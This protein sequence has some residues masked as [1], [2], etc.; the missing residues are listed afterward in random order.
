MPK[1]AILAT[2]GVSILANIERKLGSLQ[3]PPEVRQL[4][5]GSSRL[6]PDDPRQAEFLRHAEDLESPLAKIVLDEVARDPRGMSAE[7]NTIISF[8][9]DWPYTPYIDEL[10]IYLYPTDTGTSIF[11]A[12]MIKRY[13]TQHRDRFIEEARLRRECKI[14]CEVNVLRRFGVDEQFFTEGLD[15]LLNKYAERIVKLKEEKF[16]VILAPVGGFKPECTYATIIGLLCGVDKV[17]YIH[18]VFRY[19]VDLPIIPVDISSQIIKLVEQI[20]TEPCP[21]HII[22]P[23]VENL[24]FTVEEL[25]D[26]KILEEIGGE[27]RIAPWIIKILNLKGFKPPSQH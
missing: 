12:N 11:C 3:V 10:R 16:K 8:L 9:S 20:G 17:I 24:G 18:E 26:R 27:Y 15:D 23:I 21:R 1:V 13:V 6:R 22:E 5:E 7:L 25:K 2:V 19:F 14:E 4:L